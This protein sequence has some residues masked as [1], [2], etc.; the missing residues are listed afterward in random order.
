MGKTTKNR[1]TKSKTTKNKT[2]KSKTTKK[3][4]TKKEDDKKQGECKCTKELKQVCG[5]DGK[6]YN[7]ACLAKCAGV[8]SF[9][10]QKTETISVCTG[11]KKKKV[12]KS[13]VKPVPCGSSKKPSGGSSQTKPTPKPN[14]RISKAEKKRQQKVA[15]AAKK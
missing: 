12:C 10:D 14:L 1:T 13:I 15:S 4:D 7:N 6:T 5:S 2:T 9:S 8:K 11:T 3:E